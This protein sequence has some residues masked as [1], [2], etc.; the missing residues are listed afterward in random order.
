MNKVI[1]LANVGLIVVLT[2]CVSPPAIDYSKVEP[3]CAMKCQMNDAACTSRYSGFPLIMQAQCNP[4]V[5]ACV[6]ACPL[7]SGE[8]RGATTANKLK[9]LDT[10]RKEGLISDAEYQSKRQEILK[11]M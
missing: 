10:L 5:E 7:A 8:S 11:S 4:L 2:G 9:E 1:H 3:Q 6:N